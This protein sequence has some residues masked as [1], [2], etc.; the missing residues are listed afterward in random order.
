MTGLFFLGLAAGLVAAVP[1]AAVWSRRNETRVRRLEQRARRAE[2]LAELGTLTGGLAHEIKNPLS[3][4]GLNV[5]LIREDLAELE[6]HATRAADPGHRSAAERL[7]RT[8][9]RVDGLLRESTRLREIL[10]DFLRFAGRVRLDR[11]PTDVNQLCEELSDFFAP[12]AEAAGVR[13]RTDLRYAGGPVPLD[14]SLVKQALLNLLINACQAIEADRSRPDRAARP[15]E[16]ILRTDDRIG[17]EPGVLISVTDTG[18][19]IAPDVLATVFRPYVSTKR[20]GTGLGL[21]TARRLAEEHGGT[22]TVHSEPGSGSVFTLRLPAAPR[23]DA[24]GGG[25]PVPPPGH[26]CSVTASSSGQS[27]ES[28]PCG[29]RPRPV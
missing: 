12:Q 21:P 10:E 2:R 24:E 13:L 18:P 7:G 6:A 29:Q 28:K 19:G 25:D 4:L 5:Q 8:R 27:N 22:L 26:Q 17:R 16:L 14:G 23:P 9:R 1:A 15:D 3:T 11:R 20:G